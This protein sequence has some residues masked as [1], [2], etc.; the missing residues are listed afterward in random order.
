[1]KDY[2][3]QRYLIDTEH[4]A[5][6]VAVGFEDGTAG[7]EWREFDADGLTAFIEQLENALKEITSEQ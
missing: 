3:G 2:Y 6:L 4:Y 7:V 1:M 5:R